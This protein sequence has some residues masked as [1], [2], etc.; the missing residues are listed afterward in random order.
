MALPLSGPITLN[1]INTELGRTSGSTI[2]LRSAEQG[3]YVA[4]N[5]YSCKK[6]DGFDPARLSEWY[7]YDHNALQAKNRFI[8]AR[9][10]NTLT[11]QNWDIYY[12]VNSGSW[13]AFATSIGSG[14]TTCLQRGS[15]ITINDND[16]FYVSV[17][18]SS[19]GVPAS[20]NATSGTT[21][22]CPTAGTQYNEDLTPFSVTFNA[23][24][25]YISI[26]VKVNSGALV[27][28]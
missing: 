11:T 7:G 25:L 16:T 15:G 1:D 27:T 13:S 8:Y 4:I 18:N 9:L 2:Q 14:A 5:Q 24:T 3:G 26:T 20:Y 19:T 12:K 6:P 10:E 23:C 17:R 21:A 22:S 28:I